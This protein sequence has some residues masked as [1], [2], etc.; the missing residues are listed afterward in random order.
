MQIEIFAICDAATDYGGRLN[1]LGAF[2]GLAS[3]SLPLH[4]DRF[5]IAARIRCVASEAGKHAVSVEIQ[6]PRGAPV[7]PA[8]PAQIAVKIPPGRASVAT[9][10]VLNINGLRFHNFGEHQIVLSIDG[11]RLASIPL[12]ILQAKGRGQIRNP[13]EN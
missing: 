9:N 12:I 3:P 4:R 6:D 13:M 7:V 5:S 8:M 10:L 1:L 2:E 11:E